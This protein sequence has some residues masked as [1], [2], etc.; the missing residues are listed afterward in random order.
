M[1][2]NKLS[3]YAL[4]GLL[5]FAQGSILAYFTALNALYLLSF[6][7]SMS[8]V[9]IFSA[10]ALIPFVL[11]IFFGMLS[12]HVNLLGRGH[13]QPYIVLG[14]VI[15]AVCLFI[16]PFIKPGPLLLGVCPVS[17]RDDVGHG[18]V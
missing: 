6:N 11:K 14:L 1:L 7:L 8:Q 10:I 4:F 9:G 17:I 15:Q 12:D 16:A 2:N 18:A 5:Y 3:R 13:R